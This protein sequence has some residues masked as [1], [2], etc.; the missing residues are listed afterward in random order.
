MSGIFIYFFKLLQP[1][2]LARC[3]ALSRDAIN[4]DG[5][6]NI[7]IVV[8]I[9]QAGTL[10]QQ[11]KAQFTVTDLKA[12]GDNNGVP[13]DPPSGSTQAFI[14]PAAGSIVA[15]RVA[16]GLVKSHDF[17]LKAAHIK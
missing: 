1:Q 13:S 14:P 6:M 5:L 17:F 10:W 7:T 16:L 12:S 15:L 3:L 9:L 2:N 4:I 11:Q 8:I